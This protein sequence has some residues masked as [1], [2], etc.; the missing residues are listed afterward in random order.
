MSKTFVLDTNVLLHNA[1][2]IES[3]SD[4][5]VVLPMAVIEELDKFKG[6]NDELGRNA[7]QVIRRLDSLR[8]AGNLR[9]GV[10]LNNNGILKIMATPD[11]SGLDTGL[12]VKVADNLILS[13]AYVLSKKGENVIFVSKDINAR[14][15]ADALGLQAV[16]F[17]KQKV[18]LDELYVG[19]SEIEVEGTIVD[20]FFKNETLDT[21]GIGRF[22]NEFVLM[23]DKTNEKHN[24]LARVVKPEKVKHLS[25][26]YDRVWNIQSR[27]K[28]QR[29]AIELLMD[30]E[31]LIV[32]LV[33]QAGTGKTLLALA[34]ALQA[35]LTNHQYDRILVSRPIIPM[36]KDIGYLPGAKEEKLSHWMQPIFDNLTYLMRNGIH[37][38]NSGKKKKLSTQEKIHR[39]LSENTIGLEALTYIR[40]RS[41]PRQYVIVDEAQN[42]TPHEV[43]TIISRSGEGTKM[44]LTG[45]PYQIDNPYLDASSNGLIYAAERLKEQT[46]HGHITLR[47]SERSNLAAIAA[48]FL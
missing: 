24:A 36:G 16:D 7:R 40:G 8:V 15:K 37:E 35:T 27:N 44:V 6:H 41:I 26:L 28:E 3:F 38:D 4:N 25:N 12:E 46:I 21:P 31:V 47:K 5:V 17:E 13:L 14:I 11:I 45:D 18:N 20:A 42:L 23:K 2:S 48:E 33:G 39:L 1:D 34:A 32:T 19:Y 9:D 30:P 22:P 43:K 10:P 29:L